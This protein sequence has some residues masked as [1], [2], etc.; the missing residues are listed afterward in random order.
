MTAR[1]AIDAALAERLVRAQFPQWA[2]LPLTPVPADGWDHRNFRLGD[3]MLVRLPS[4]A[5]YA[6][7][8]EI[9][10]RWLPRLA[11]LLPLRVPQPLAQGAPGAGYPWHWSVLRWIEGETAAHAGVAD[12]VAF[13]RDLAAFLRALQRIDTHDGPPPGPRNFHRGGALATYDAEARSA[14][15]ALA[16][17]IDARAA[18]RVWDAAMSTAWSAPPV[19]IHGDMSAGNLLVRDGRLA[20]V[21]DFGLLAVGDPACDLAIAWTFMDAASR[22]VFR[23]Q[24]AL[25]D[26]T[27]E[28]GRGWALWKAAI[29]AAGLSDTNAV[30]KAQAA[31]TLREVL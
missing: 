13:A 20:A 19:W 30:E 17:A 4:D 24:L 21:I 3:A 18:L 9:E 15:E 7:Q 8:V 2:H 23:S 26:A 31:R 11:P 25:D 22:A 16:G 1:S 29:V 27:W 5:P 12:L 14:I 28:R 6:G 10:Q